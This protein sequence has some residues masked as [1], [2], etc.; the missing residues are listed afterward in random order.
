[1]LKLNIYK[2]FK[3]LGSFYTTLY[4]KN[5]DSNLSIIQVSI[6]RR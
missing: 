6:G 3:L 2:M 1:M 5:G 4:K